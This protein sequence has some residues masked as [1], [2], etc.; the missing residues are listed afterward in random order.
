VPRLELPD[1]ASQANG[2]A[3]SGDREQHPRAL[4]T[5]HLRDC[6]G[7]TRGFYQRSDAKHRH[8]AAMQDDPVIDT[9]GGEEILPT[10]LAHAPPSLRRQL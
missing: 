9:F 8:R 7:E 10:L 1:I 3:G 6:L 2:Q 5:G 4:K